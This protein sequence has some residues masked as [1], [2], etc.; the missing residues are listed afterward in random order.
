MPFNL[1]F[2]SLAVRKAAA[3][4]GIT[5]GTFRPVRSGIDVTDQVV[6]TNRDDKS[7]V[8]TANAQEYASQFTWK[9][10]KEQF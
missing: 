7:V 1:Y 4:R 2:A 10:I 5:R 8:I 3:I 9:E 6:V